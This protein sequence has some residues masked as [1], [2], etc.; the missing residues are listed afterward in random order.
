[1]DPCIL[2]LFNERW[3]NKFCYNFASCWLFLLNQ[4]HAIINVNNVM[5]V[6]YSYVI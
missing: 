4:Y 3:N 5:T 1:M 2:V 6:F